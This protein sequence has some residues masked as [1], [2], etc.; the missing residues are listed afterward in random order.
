MG[1]FGYLVPDSLGQM[2]FFSLQP[3]VPEDARD[4]ADVSRTYVLRESVY[5][6]TNN[7]LFCWTPSESSSPGSDMAG[8]M[9]HWQPENTFHQSFVVDEVFYIREWEKGLLR[10]QGD[11]LQLVPGGEQFANERIYVMLPF[12]STPLGMTKS[13]TEL[14]HSHVE[15]SRS[16]IGTRMQGLFLYDGQTFHPFKTEADEF[17]QQNS[18]YLP[19]AVLGNGR[20]LLNTVSG[21]A[22]LLDRSGK[23]LQTIDR[24][25]GL[26]DNTVYYVYS[27]PARPETQWLALNNG[28]A[29]V[30]AAGPFSTFDADRGLESIVNK[31]QRHRGVLYAATGVGVFYFDAISGTFKPVTM[32]V[33]QSRDF[34]AIDGQLL[35]VTNDG[36][37]AINGDQAAFVRQSVNNDFRA[38]GVCGRSRAAPAVD[39]KRARAGARA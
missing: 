6:T 11:S 28:I 2:R 16:I 17:L 3:Q 15:R 4:F 33:E 20:L 22:V 37:Y 31:V 21:G 8:E 10:M 29:R 18:L 19:G 9:K 7:Y 38:A 30:E 1:D 32:P 5:F 25:S 23:L 13:N 26:P 27:D 36:A 39:Q 12:P 14:S 34:L 35:A 24:S